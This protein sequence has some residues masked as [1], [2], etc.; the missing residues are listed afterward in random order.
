MKKITIVMCA[1]AIMSF[2]ACGD[3][4][5]NDTEKKITTTASNKGGIVSQDELDEDGAVNFDD[6]IGDDSSEKH[7]EN[8]TTTTISKP[9]DL[10]ENSDEI[11]TS[12]T[13]VGTENTDTIT[14][15]VPEKDNV[16][17]T[18]V[19]TT[20]KP[21]QSVTTTTKAPVKTDKTTTTTK[22]K[23][24]NPLQSEGK[25]PLDNLDWGELVPVG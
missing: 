20:K 12:T 23:A 7:D 24:E 15:S 22:P 19:T 10:P 6:I 11:D 21:A 14:N 16:T 3:D 2:T 13:T 8:A 1:L 4:K 5:D 25:A 18:T 9:L 17:V